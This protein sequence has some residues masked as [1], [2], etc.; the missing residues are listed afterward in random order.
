MSRSPKKHSSGFYDDNDNNN[1][2]K[3]SRQKNAGYG[4]TSSSSDYWRKSNGMKYRLPTP[5][6]APA[7]SPYK[8]N[9]PDDEIVEIADTDS[10]AEI[11]YDN[12]N[13]ESS[14]DRHR[15]QGD[16]D[17]VDTEKREDSTSSDVIFVGDSTEE[18]EK[19]SWIIS[20]SKFYQQK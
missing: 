11:T 17:S 4:E 12:N 7:L 19:L 8:I 13:E 15:V 10:E 2:K 9:N 3:S 5:P 20:D 16:R 18:I 1:M 14:P 6:P